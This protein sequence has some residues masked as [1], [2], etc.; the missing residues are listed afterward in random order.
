[1]ELTRNQVKDI[2]FGLRVGRN[3]VLADAAN[4]RDPPEQYTPFI[5]R[6][7]AGIEAIESYQRARSKGSS[8]GKHPLTLEN[9]NEHEPKTVRGVL[10]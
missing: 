1:M 5:M 6:I 7:D 4:F 10:S 9:E 2:L 8:L 3:R